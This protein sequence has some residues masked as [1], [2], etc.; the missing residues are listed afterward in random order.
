VVGVKYTTARS[1]AQKAVDRVFASWGQRGAPPVSGY[2]RLPGGEIDRFQEFLDEAVRQ[3][4]CGLAPGVVHDLVVNYGSAYPQVLSYFIAPPGEAG[5]QEREAAL[6]RAQAVY[7]VREEAAQKLSDVVL[8][9]TGL[10]S[11]G[12]PPQAAL[13][14]CAAVM[15]DELGWSGEQTRQELNEVRGRYRLAGT[16]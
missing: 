11:A 13:E 14:L 7:A 10:G 8:R 15:A 9:R 12:Q 16:S 1:V 5:D 3:Q 6:L 4:P 2:T